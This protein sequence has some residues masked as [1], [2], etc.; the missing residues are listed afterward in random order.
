[1]TGD[2]EMTDEFID[3]VFNDLA[4]ERQRDLTEVAG[5]HPRRQA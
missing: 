4:A 3:S 5:Q 2:K 1:V